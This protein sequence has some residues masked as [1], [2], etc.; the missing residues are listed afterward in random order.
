MEE[1]VNMPSKYTR[2][3]TVKAFPTRSHMILKQFLEMKK[4]KHI[5]SQN[6]DGLHRK[7]GILRHQIS[8]LHGN[9]NLEICSSCGRDYMRDFRT[10][11][12]DNAFNIHLTGRNCDNKSC[13]G[14][15]FDTIINFGEPLNKET[16]NEAAQHSK[17]ADLCLALGS[18][19]IVKPAMLFPMIVG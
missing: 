2:K 7:S 6:I 16:I 10:R 13:N 15:L 12:S 19:L 14:E 3:E 17:N 4:M 1:F 9:T 8:E 18:S 5:I 11:N